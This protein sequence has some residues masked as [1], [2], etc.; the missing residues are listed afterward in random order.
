MGFLKGTEESHHWDFNA[1]GI[2]LVKLLAKSIDFL[3]AGFLLHFLF[4]M[5][6]IKI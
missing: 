4:L 2:I 3:G 1:T 6:I 5:E